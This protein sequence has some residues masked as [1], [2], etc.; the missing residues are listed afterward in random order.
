MNIFLWKKGWCDIHM[1]YQQQVLGTQPRRWLTGDFGPSYAGKA[2]SKSQPQFLAILLLARGA[3]WP[4]PLVK[5][6]ILFLSLSLSTHQAPPW[7]N[8]QWLTFT[9]IHVH[10]EKTQ[11]ANWFWRGFVNDWQ[12]TNDT[13]ASLPKAK[14][15]SVTSTKPTVHDDAGVRLMS[16][17]R[18]KLPAYTLPRHW[19]ISIRNWYSCKIGF[20]VSTRQRQIPERPFRW[21]YIW[22]D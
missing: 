10:N 19:D 15:C 2:P 1:R 8:V 11:F 13:W 4:S 16:Y 6:G 22:I 3:V 14:R 9:G 20:L 7:S 21:V 17:S 12:I 18:C 5:G